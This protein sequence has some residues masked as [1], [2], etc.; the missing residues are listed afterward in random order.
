MLSALDCLFDTLKTHG[1]S[2]TPSFWNTICTQILFP[3]FNILRSSSTDNTAR[4]KSHED[5]SVW[6]STTL[7]SA[8][9]NMIDLWTEYFEVM[10]EYLDGLLDIL[11]ACICQ[12][13]LRVLSTRRDSLDPSLP[14]SKMEIVEKSLPRFVLMCRKR[15]LSSNRYIMLPTTS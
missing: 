10:Q 8:L 6:L 5:M 14:C 3:I 1:K 9:R 11:V 7:I 12:G 13:K 4:F 15:Y 2:F